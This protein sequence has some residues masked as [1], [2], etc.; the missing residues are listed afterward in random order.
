MEM[1]V[2]A[3]AGMAFQM[4]TFTLGQS[5]CYRRDV[6]SSSDWGSA[7]FHFIKFRLFQKHLLAIEMD[8]V[9]HELLAFIM[10][11]FINNISIT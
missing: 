1:G 6:C 7:I 9:A 4:I 5:A 2:V 10:S 8:A 11:N 3:H